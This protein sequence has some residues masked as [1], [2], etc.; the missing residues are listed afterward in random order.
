M[1]L[2]AFPNRDF[3]LHSLF[4]PEAYHGLEIQLGTAMASNEMIK[5][6]LDP[7]FPWELDLNPKTEWMILSPSNWKVGPTRHVDMNCIGIL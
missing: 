2:T 6:G 3:V 1:T 7:F 4:N 5:A